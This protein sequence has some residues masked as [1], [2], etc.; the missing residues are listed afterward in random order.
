MTAFHGSDELKKRYLARVRSAEQMDNIVKG[1]YGAISNTGWRGC[2][3]GVIMHGTDH[4]ALAAALGIPQQVIDL[5]PDI[6]DNLP[7]AEAQTFPARFIEAIPVGADCTLVWPQFA[8]WL[9]TDPADGVLRIA[10]RPQTQTVIARVAAMYTRRIAG[11]E[12]SATEWQDADAD[13]D[14]AMRQRQCATLLRLL[15]TA[16]VSE[17]VSDAGVP[18]AVTAGR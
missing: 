8:V 6:H 5:L 3:V 17:S 4:A 16:P 13:A 18:T 2:A 15:G 7:D 14:A 1:T 9:L 11:D 12:S 10:T